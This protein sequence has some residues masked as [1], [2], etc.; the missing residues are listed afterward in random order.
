MEETHNRS[1]SRRRQRHLLVLLVLG[2]LV[3]GASAA[4]AISF[5]DPSRSLGLGTA[6]LKST[7]INI[8]NWALGLLGLIGVGLVLYGGWIWMTSAGNEE[9]VRRAKRIILNAAIGL[10]II[11]LSWAIVNFVLNFGNTVTGGGPGTSCTV[12]D[13]S[14]C[15][16]CVAG[17]PNNQW[18][19]DP[20]NPGCTLPVE[21]FEI[22]DIT[23]SCENPPPAG[24][25]R[26]D[27]YRCSAVSIVFN[28]KVKDTTVPP[29]V[30][31]DSFKIQQCDNTSDFANCN[32][33]SQP[34]PLFGASPDEIVYSGTTPTGTKAEFVL[35][36]NALSFVHA[37]QL[38]EASTF[39]ELIIPRNITDLAGNNIQF[40]V[41][42]I[43]QCIPASG[44]PIPGC[45]GTPTEIHWIFQVGLNSDTTPPSLVSSYPVSDTA[46]PSYPDRNVNR[47]PVLSVAYDE[48][49]APWTITKANITIAPVTAPPAINP[50]GSGGTVGPP[51]DAADYDFNIKP[52][53]F[54]MYFTG[55]FMLDPFA[56]YQITV[57]DLTDMCSNTQS[58]G[59]ITW[60]FQTN[61]VAPGVAY[62]YPPNGFTFACPTTPIFV[63]FTT[64]MY[65]A[66]N[67]S[68]QTV[69]VVG[70]FVESG[71]VNPAILRVFNVEDNYLGLG[72]PKDFCKTYSWLPNTGAGQLAVSTNYSADVATRLQIDTAGT[73]L[74][75]SWS[76]GTTTPDQCVQPPYISAV[77]PPSGSVGQCISVLGGYFDPATVPPFP[78]K[79]PG[80]SLT[81]AG[82]PV[83]DP[84]IK[85]WIDNAI[86]TNA[87]NVGLGSKDVQVSVAY[88]APIGTLQSN[89]MPFTFV[90]GTFDGPCLYSLSPNSGFRN[91]SYQL[92]GERFDPGSTKKIVHFVDPP[93]HPSSG[94][95]TSDTVA[96]SV[97][98]MA[99]MENNAARVSLENDKG[100]SNELPFFVSKVPPATFGVIDH[101]PTCSSDECLNT[102]IRARV[103]D[104]LD[105]ATV[106][107]STVKL[108]TCPTA[109]CDSGLSAVAVSVTAT[110]PG[111]PIDI[112]VQP[113]AGLSL[114]TFYRVAIS[115][116]ASGVTS[117]S[118]K[119]LGG[120]TYDAD[121]DGTN[122]AYS[123]TFGTAP[124][125]TEC[126]L[127]TVDCQPASTS[128]AVGFTRAFSSFAYSDPNSCY[129]GGEE[130]NPFDYTWGWS[131]S[132]PAN[133]TVAPAGPNP[134]T[135]A[136]G[137]AATA[138]PIEVRGTVVPSGE[139]D[140]CFLS[141]TTT[142]CVV[143]SDCD[144]AGPDLC[145]NSIC[146]S[147]QCTPVIHDFSPVIGRVGDW[148][149]VNGCYFGSYVSGQSQVW[150]L[151][152]PGNGDDRLGLW[153]LPA[154]CG[155]PGSTWGD[156][157]II[158]EVPNKTTPSS[159]DDVTA[160]GPLR[161][162]RG[163]DA[164]QADSSG[165][166]DPSAPVATPGICKVTPGAGQEG[167][168]VTLGG[169]NFGL[170]QTP[171]VDYVTFYDSKVVPV[172]DTTWTGDQEV[173]VKVPVGASNNMDVAHPWFPDEITL[174]NDGIDSNHVNFDVL[175]PAC[176]VCAADNQCGGGG[177]QGCAAF[178]PFMCCANRPTI[179]QH[180]P[181]GTN[182]C[183]NAAIT[184]SFKDV[185]SGDPIAMDTSTI[186]NATV[187]VEELPAGIPIAISS[188]TFPSSSSVVVTPATF[189]G[190]N[191]TYRVVISGDPITTDN[192]PVGVL[193]AKHVG[194]NG[195]YQWQFTT[196]DADNFC[197]VDHADLTPSSFLFTSFGSS[198][199]V[200]ARMLDPGG[201]EIFPVYGVYDWEWGW[202]SAAPAIATVTNNVVAGHADKNQTITSV[203]NGN[204]SITATATAGTGWTGTRSATASVAVSACAQPWPTPPPFVD[205]TTNFSTWYCR[206]NGASPL[207]YLTIHQ[208][209]SAPIPGNSIDELLRQFFF[210]NPTLNPDTNI[211]DAVGILVYE[212]E[213]HLSPVAWYEKKFGRRAGSATQ[214][215]DGYEAMRVGTTIYLAGTNV[216]GGTLYTN[217]YVI[218]YNDNAGAEVRQIYDTMLTNLLLNVNSW[219]NYGGVPRDKALEQIRLDTK[220]YADIKDYEVALQT[221]A[222][223]NSGSFPELTAGSYIKGMSTSKWPSWGDAFGHELQSKAGDRYTSH[224]DP[225]N[226]FQECVLPSDPPSCT[227]HVD[228]TT[229]YYDQAT[230]WNEND[231]KFLCNQDSHIYAYQSSN[232]A[233]AFDLFA[234]FDYNGT[235]SW[236]TGFVNPCPAG[237]SCQCFNFSLHG[238]GGPVVIPDTVP[239]TVPSGLSAA[240]VSSSQID[241]SWTPSTDAVSGMSGYRLFQSLSPSSFPAVPFVQVAHPTATFSH[242][243]LNPSTPYYYRV[244]AVDNNGNESAPSNVASATTQAGPDMVPPSNVASLVATPGDNTVTLGWNAPPEPDF[245]GVLVLRKTGSVPSFAWNDASAASIINLPAGT[246]TTTDATA[247]NGTTY[248]YGVFS[249]DG[250]PNYAAGTF[251]QATPSSGVFSSDVQNLVASPGNG[252]IDFT[253]VNP[254]SPAYVGVTIRRSTTAFPATPADGTAAG[255]IAKPQASW[256]DIGLT[257]GT[258]YFYTFFA[259]DGSSHYGTGVQKQA[260]PSSTVFSSPITAFSAAP[261]DATVLLTWSNPA[262]AAYAGVVIRR[263]TTGFPTGPTDG[264]LVADV[265]PPVAQYTDN[266]VT[267]GTLYYYGAFAHDATPS[268]AAGAFVQAQPD[269]VAPVISGVNAPGISIESNRVIITW[270]TNEPSSTFIDLGRISFYDLGFIG[271]VEA[272]TNHQWDSAAYGIPILQNTRYM[273]RVTSVDPQG[274][275]TTD[276][277]HIFLTD[278][279]DARGHRWE[280]YF[281]APLKSTWSGSSNAT[282]C[283]HGCNQFY[284]CT[285][286]RLPD[287]SDSRNGAAANPGAT[288]T[289]GALAF[290]DCADGSVD[291][292]Q[293]PSGVITEAVLAAWVGT[294]L[295]TNIEFSTTCLD[296]PPYSMPFLPYGAWVAD[297]TG[298]GSNSARTDGWNGGTGTFC[299]F[300]T[301][302]TV[303]KTLPIPIITP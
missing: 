128:V 250:I 37:H 176:S 232:S 112:N 237:S 103:N 1:T 273:F 287:C 179:D 257:N 107:T 38:F 173:T 63:Q 19:L 234:H 272:V 108:F 52:N 222:S 82:T 223:A 90:G 160:T 168:N 114:N 120:L 147:N 77:S 159:L 208:G 300:W 122:D 139:T 262:D 174:R 24:E 69:P 106:S 102:S 30:V 67:N 130:L 283:D 282:T 27:V 56:W 129:P 4:S 22:R 190:R 217:M 172:T 267:N 246:N 292:P 180:Q 278:Q 242:T 231:K 109:A 93:D 284:T 207:P 271:T 148:V 205:A 116:G 55:S 302:Q 127:S 299:T 182:V 29:R 197:R 121:G 31:D 66:A 7:A 136:T 65:D 200:T 76:F 181:V 247:V 157:Q 303:T 10:V 294:R 236:V 43:G 184:F 249:Y 20:S 145:D 224:T 11:L 290:A 265:A 212:N 45:T 117:T 88:P 154:V 221:Y 49:I 80:D 36:D 215:I 123:W 296:S 58:P 57:K 216:A 270:T 276:I 137:V 125:A 269:N 150:F 211:H 289:C 59:T 42:N 255:E 53:G 71:T 39:Y 297:I 94:G 186:S 74:D 105:V 163:T 192:V 204:T 25:Y 99:A 100:T 16:D 171:G 155:A 40:S 293:G 149:T 60:R 134:S 165:T 85:S 86:V 35:N 279:V 251:V 202:A 175:P 230:C 61:D 138:S 54:E 194:M 187:R 198:A 143:D 70:G 275:S 72:N 166:F 95:W 144:P 238:T 169:Q 177:Q 241:L 97:V 2:F 33:P 12:G 133:A 68:C 8:I 46:S 6:D 291:L 18:I 28:H 253:W 132:S 199:A 23:T 213:D 124:A 235:G 110:P 178:G 119:E 210:E 151:Q 183:R 50:D 142:G 62:V 9:R 243:G 219:A 206:D 17:V 91:Q 218:G 131:S 126:A 89:T 170:S 96:Q 264:T 21:T 92:I 277:N 256:S 259:H 254:G 115:G 64:S 260:V 214:K 75:A 298:I 220:R 5:E 244:T 73:L 47:K 285:P 26:K 226:T 258:T 225:L 164:S 146:V 161:V 239:P 84:D 78:G 81:F 135:T 48:A 87:P 104:T 233:T 261:G 111:T 227:S 280:G 98:P 185:I 229:C 83:P 188:F 140:M 158:I 41:N 266:G 301:P 281:D 51:I 268:Y 152:N 14:G 245:A 113:L 118:G 203:A 201:T 240:S 153:P 44:I 101:V 162:I 248:T 13:E 209:S 189:L 288:K 286:Q 141:V 15:Y 156:K 228:T 32:N 295:P 79:G 252:K 196:V 193:S 263:S 3:L 191:K 274:N 195:N 167:S 34:V